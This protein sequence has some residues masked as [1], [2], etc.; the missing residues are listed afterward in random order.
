MAGAGCGS[1]AFPVGEVPWTRIESNEEAM[2]E[3][4]WTLLHVLGEKGRAVIRPH[5]LENAESEQYR[6]ALVAMNDFE[7]VYDFRARNPGTDRP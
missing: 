2:S 4:F 6:L 1:G 7:R 3:A 5:L